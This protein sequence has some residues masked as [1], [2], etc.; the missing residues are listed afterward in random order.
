MIRELSRMPVP[1]VATTDSAIES[2][3]ILAQK[4]SPKA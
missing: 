1:M 2:A 3:I 4:P